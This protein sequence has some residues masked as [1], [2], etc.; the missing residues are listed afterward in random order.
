MSWFCR[1][2]FSTRSSAF[3]SIPRIQARYRITAGEAARFTGNLA[4]AAQLVAPPVIVKPITLSDPADD[5][6][7][8]TA[9]R[10]VQWIFCVPEIPGTSRLPP[11]RRFATSIASV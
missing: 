2:S 8:Y 5:P 3:C 4:D 7:L 9:A 10:M 6:V 11:R 1:V